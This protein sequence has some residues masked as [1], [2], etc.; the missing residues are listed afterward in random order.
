MII[1]N[2]II[3]LH[4]YRA[5]AGHCQ[6]LQINMMHILSRLREFEAWSRIEA[7]SS[8]SYQQ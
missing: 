5:L 6:H 4:F 2:K 1:F 8:I 7:A 3:V